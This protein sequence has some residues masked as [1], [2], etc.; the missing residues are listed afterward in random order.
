MSKLDKLEGQSK[1]N[2]VENAIAAIHQ[3]NSEDLNRVVE[4]VKLQRTFLS[5]SAA[6][7]LCVGDLVRFAARSGGTITGTVRKVNR[8]TVIVDAHV[9]GTRYRVPAAMC[10]AV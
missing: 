5:R 4:A 9:G 10:S 6:Q 3:M 7:G 2:S 8:K 1:M